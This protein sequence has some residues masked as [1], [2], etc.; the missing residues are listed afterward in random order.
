MRY[1]GSIVVILLDQGSNNLVHSIATVSQKEVI[2]ADKLA[3]AHKKD[4]HAQACHIL[5]QAQNVHITAA[6]CNGLLRF[7]QA[8]HGLQLVTHTRCLL[9]G[10]IICCSLHALLQITF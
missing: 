7:T 8:L 3:L 10:I 5:T 2:T 6:I 1:I 9:K 4:L